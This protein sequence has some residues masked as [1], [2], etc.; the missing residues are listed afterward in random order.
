MGVDDLIARE[1]RTCPKCGADDCR[2]WLTQQ[3]AKSLLPAYVIP[4]W[5][6]KEMDDDCAFTANSCPTCKGKCCRDGD[7][8]YRVHHMAAECYEHWCDDCR[9]GQVPVVQPDPRD[10]LIAELRAE[11]EKLREAVA[12]DDAL[13]DS[14][15][16]YATEDMLKI[17][18]MREAI[19]DLPPT[20][21]PEWAKARAACRRA[22]G[23]EED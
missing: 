11:V 21:F 3:A 19:A 10:A 9:D 8:G 22:A 23:L 18:A 13:M 20:V 7:L 15:R 1:G 14:L 12:T 16:E 6:Q 17:K 2:R 5:K 4:D